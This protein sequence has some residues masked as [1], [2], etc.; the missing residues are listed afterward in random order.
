MITLEGERRQLAHFCELVL[1]DR[2]LHQRLR[3]T[4]TLREFVALTVQLGAERGCRFT[5]GMVET[6]LHERRRAWLERWL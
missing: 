3:A 4:T 2:E 6:A 1:A 5:T